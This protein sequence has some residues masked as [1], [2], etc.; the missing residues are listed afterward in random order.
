[1]HSFSFIG[2]FFHITNAEK[3]A[4]LLEIK[5]LKYLNIC[6]KYPNYFKVIVCY[7]KT[8]I[9]YGKTKFEWQHSGASKFQLTLH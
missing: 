8:M 6:V 9:S 3:S 4:I 5:N 2:S 1:M 7:K